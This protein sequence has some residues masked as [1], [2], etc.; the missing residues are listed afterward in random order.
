LYAQPRQF[1]DALVPLFHGSLDADSYRF[2]SSFFRRLLVSVSSQNTMV[3]LCGADKTRRGNRTPTNGPALPNKL[4]GPPPT[5]T[6]A[7]HVHDSTLVKTVSSLT[8]SRRKA[9]DASLSKSLPFLPHSPSPSTVTL[10]ITQSSSVRTTDQ[11]RDEVDGGR[12]RRG[13]IPEELLSPATTSEFVTPGRSLSNPPFHVSLVDRC[14]YGS[15]ADDG[16]QRPT[17]SWERKDFELVR[18][19]SSRDRVG[20]P[21]RDVSCRDLKERKGRS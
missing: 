5:P 15:G 13:S 10:E 6:F 7:I 2:P 20:T 3:M 9:S 18:I 14:S 11:S 1:P 17:A 19:G 12:A 16:E 4:P 8:M 21:P